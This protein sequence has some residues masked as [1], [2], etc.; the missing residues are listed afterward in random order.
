MKVLLVIVVGLHFA[1]LGANGVALCALPYAVLSGRHDW[2]LVVP[3]LHWLIWSASGHR[4]VLTDAE[5]YCRRRLGLAE[6][7]GFIEHYVLGR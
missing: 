2:M 4:C 5:N 3:L 1:L 6:I 7:A